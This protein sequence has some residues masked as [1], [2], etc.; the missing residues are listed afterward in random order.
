MHIV[1]AVLTFGVGALYIMVQAGVS[2]C[3][4][5]HVHGKSM[6]WIRFSV[7]AWSTVSII[8]SILP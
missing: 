6:F 1:G 3:M 8:S 5:P 4:Q 2:Y 7:A